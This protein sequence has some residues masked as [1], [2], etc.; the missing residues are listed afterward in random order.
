MVSKSFIAY[1]CL[2]GFTTSI[3][4]QASIA[5]G[6]GG[7]HV[8]RSPQ[9]NHPARRAFANERSNFE[10]SPNNGIP[11]TSPPLP[12]DLPDAVQ[13]RAIKRLVDRALGASASDAGSIFKSLLKDFEDAKAPPGDGFTVPPPST[14]PTAPPGNAV[15]AAS[16]PAQPAAPG[17]NAVAPGSPQ[18]PPT[19][20]VAAQARAIQLL[21]DRALA[22][23]ERSILE[24]SLNH[25]LARLKVSSP[26]DSIPAAPPAQSGLP[27]VV[28]YRRFEPIFEPDV[29]NDFLPLPNY[30]ASAPQPTQSSL[31]DAVEYRDIKLLAER[32][33][34]NSKRSTLEPLL[35]HIHARLKVSSPD[36]SIPAA[37]PSQSGLPN[38]VGY[39]DIKLLVDRA[40]APS[41]TSSIFKAF[42]DSLDDAKAPPG[43]GV[44]DIPSDA[45]PAAPA[46]NVPGASP[47]S[48]PVAPNGSQTRAAVV[49]AA[50]ANRRRANF[51]RTCEFFC[52]CSVV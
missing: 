12:A 41:G 52:A 17:G 6:L 5:P 30:G 28:G 24:R 8:Q 15:N 49:R 32:A 18:A 39:R 45:S 43:S 23:S 40:L 1:A 27:D 10:C 44:T 50:N 31:P 22:N 37:P 4:A 7:E 14:P 13:Y 48:Q 21:A 2:F 47:P 16:P 46:G 26:D 25:I 42:L 38:V 51:E 34:S 19:A 36:D 35:N 20:P 11:V 9:T 3:N 29:L 33:L